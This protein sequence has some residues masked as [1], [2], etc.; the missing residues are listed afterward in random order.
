[1]KRK[2]I[3][4]TLVATALLLADIFS[5]ACVGGCGNDSFEAWFALSNVPFFIVLPI[6]ISG[7]AILMWEFI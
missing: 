4:L 5:K 3:G 2:I 7:I 1:M 6:L